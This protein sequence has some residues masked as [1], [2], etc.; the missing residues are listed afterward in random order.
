MENR[1]SVANIVLIE[2]DQEDI[3]IFTEILKRITTEVILTTIEEGTTALRML[4][5]GECVADIIFLDLKLPGMGGLEL[6]TKMRRIPVLQNT[7]VVIYSSENDHS[8]IDKYRNL[9][10]H[11]VVRKSSNISVL[12]S[13]LRN[14][15]TRYITI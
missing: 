6:L 1:K 4:A 10:V 2:D 13:E 15:L 12:E 11:G 14:C 3:E 9:S 5:T 7:S 8:V